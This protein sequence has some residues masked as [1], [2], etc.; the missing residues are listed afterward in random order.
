[1]CQFSSGSFSGGQII[2]ADSRSAKSVRSRTA[3][4]LA[5]NQW[6]ALLWNLLFPSLKKRAEQFFTI[7]VS[8]TPASGLSASITSLLILVWGSGS[9]CQLVRY[10]SIMDIRY[11]VTGITEEGI[12]ISTLA[13]NFERIYMVAV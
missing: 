11:S 6:R 13:I 8:S 7:A 10:G 3:S 1:M 5:A 9:I 12:S 4:R 2:S